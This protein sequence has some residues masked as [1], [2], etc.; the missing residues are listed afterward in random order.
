MTLLN[1]LLNYYHI[2]NE[3]Y[4]K[5]IAPHTLLDFNDGHEFDNVEE[6]VKLTRKMMKEN[7]KIIIYGDYDCDGIMGV[8][9]LKKM[10]DYLSYDVDYYV[11]SRYLDNYGLNIAKAQEYVLDGYEFVITVDN[12]VCANEAIDYLKDNNVTVLVILIILKIIMSPY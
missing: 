9:I 6:A 12:G 8:S 10:F 2:S 11:P 5:L 4:Q 3:D 1:K 7:K